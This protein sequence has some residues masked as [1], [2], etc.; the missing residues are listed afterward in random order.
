MADC[1]DDAGKV[2]IC[3][4]A[5][6]GS[7]CVW[8]HKEDDP[9]RKITGI[10]QDVAVIPDFDYERSFK[11]KKRLAKY[12][13]KYTFRTRVSTSVRPRTELALE[14]VTEPYDF[15]VFRCRFHTPLD[16]RK[17]T[18]SIELRGIF[19]G[20]AWIDDVVLLPVGQLIKVD[21]KRD[22]AD[23]DVCLAKGAHRVRVYGEGAGEGDLWPRAVRVSLG[24]VAQVVDVYKPREKLY[25]RNGYFRVDTDGETTLTL[26]KSEKYKESDH[27]RPNTHYRV[28]R[29]R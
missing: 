25:G 17:V 7:K 27:G 16:C 20:D 10:A 22:R 2:E 13:D 5:G 9:S 4:D 21:W 23:V 28:R 15:G 1:R 29:P 24:D 3:S 18:V 11:A 14:I 6:S 12:A 8:L 26:A 19:A